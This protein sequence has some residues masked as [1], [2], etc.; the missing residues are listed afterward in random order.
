MKKYLEIIAFEKNM[1]IRRIDVT[2][3]ND[4]AIERIEGGYNIN[5]NHDLYYTNINKSQTELP[6][7]K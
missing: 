1:V 6:I 2:S 3:K 5:L 4:R 7:I